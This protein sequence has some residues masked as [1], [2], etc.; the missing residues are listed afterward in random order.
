[1][2]PI[3]PLSSITADGCPRRYKSIRD[4]QLAFLVE[5]WMEL[6]NTPELRN[7]IAE[8]AQGSLPHAADVM[9]A[10]IASQ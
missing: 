8:V 6:K 2:M 10:L 3:V 7:K 9:M 5:H 1:M 4:L